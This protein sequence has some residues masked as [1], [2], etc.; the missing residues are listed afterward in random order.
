MDKGHVSSSCEGVFIPAMTKNGLSPDVRRQ[1]VSHA[2]TLPRSDRRVKE[3]GLPL[4]C[5][6]PHPS[7]LL[8]TD[9]HLAQMMGSWHLLQ[10]T[11][12]PPAAAH[13]TTVSSLGGRFVDNLKVKPRAVKGGTGSVGEPLG[14]RDNDKANAAW[15]SWWE[16]N[17]RKQG[18]WG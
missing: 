7:A 4:H 1:A 16:N 3:E 9:Y 15:L 13:G 11:Q 6:E 2:Q 18:T 5:C 8:L 10:L 12:L 17:I 14:C